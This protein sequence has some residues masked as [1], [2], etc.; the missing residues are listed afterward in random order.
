TRNDGSAKPFSSLLLGVYEDSQLRYAGKVGTGFKDKQQKDLLKRFKPLVVKNSPFSDSPDYNKPSRFRPNPPHA[1][2]TW[3][4][5]E[6]V[7]EIHFAEIT[8][9]GVFRHPAFIAMREDKDARE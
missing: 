8:D 5:P 4:R 2:A 9:Q 3:L 7:C 1:E 6:L